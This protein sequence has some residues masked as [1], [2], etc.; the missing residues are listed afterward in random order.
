MKRRNISVNQLYDMLLD[1]Y[2]KPV[3]IYNDKIIG[4]SVKEDL[5]YIYNAYYF[6]EHV[7]SAGFFWDNEAKAWIGDIS[8]MLRMEPNVLVR[9]LFA[10]SKHSRENLINL[11][12]S[13]VVSD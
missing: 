6:R 9:F 10:T 7:K 5:I 12:K 13:L 8:C 3:I 2:E 1:I 4:I 11:L